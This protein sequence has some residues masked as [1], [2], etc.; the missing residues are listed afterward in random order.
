[1]N[2]TAPSDEA[3]VITPIPALCVLLVNLEKQKGS[4]LTEEEVLAATGKAVCMMLPKSVRL[5]MEESRGY[6]DLDLD[7]V[8]KD[9]LGFK[10]WMAQPGT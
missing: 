4:D 5:S 10:A 9:W 3:L 6:R 2:S 7:N 8:W 1:M